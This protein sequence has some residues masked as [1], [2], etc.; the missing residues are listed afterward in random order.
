MAMLNTC[1]QNGLMEVVGLVHQLKQELLYEWK[2][3]STSFFSRVKFSCYAHQVT[4]ASLFILQ[5]SAYRDQPIIR[6]IPKC[7]SQLYYC[8]EFELPVFGNIQLPFSYRVTMLSNQNSEQHPHAVHI[9]LLLEYCNK[10]KIISIT[11]TIHQ[12]IV[13]VFQGDFNIYVHSLL[14]HLP[15][16]YIGLCTGSCSLC[17]LASIAY[18]VQ[19]KS[20]GELQFAKLFSPNAIFIAFLMHMDFNSSMF[21]LPNFLPYSLNFL[22]PKFLL[23]G[24]SHECTH[25]SI[26]QS[27]MINIQ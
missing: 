17:M 27:S 6:W 2:G 19:Q 22:L 20:F 25:S 23:Y 13:H 12:I 18:T 8:K 3:S 21:F 4:V 10:V 24:T 5:S 11:C 9:Q 15:I 14:I 16:G 7:T 26:T 1:Q